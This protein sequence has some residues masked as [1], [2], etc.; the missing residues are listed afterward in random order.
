MLC[1]TYGISYSNI[2][3]SPRESVLRCLMETSTP[4]L[5][6][7]KKSC[8]AAACPRSVCVK[9]VWQKKGTVKDR[10]EVN[11]AAVTGSRQRSDREMLMS[12]SINLPFGFSNCSLQSN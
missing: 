6:R 10:H 12:F 4:S 9:I 8:T 11:I 2:K 1:A 3:L 5:A 7:V